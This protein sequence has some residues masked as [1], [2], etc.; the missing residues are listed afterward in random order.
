V[1]AAENAPGGILETWVI[2]PR[3]H[4]NVVAVMPIDFNEDVEIFRRSVEEPIV[5]GGNGNRS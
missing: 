1:E 4:E 3:P 5:V 2:I